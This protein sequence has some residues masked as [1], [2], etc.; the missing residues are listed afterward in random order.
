MTKICLYVICIQLSIL[1]QKKNWN[2]MGKMIVIP[3][4]VLYLHIHPFIYS[5]IQESLL[6]TYYVLEIFPSLRNRQ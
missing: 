4:G 5:L 2:L 3:L 1:I 6:S